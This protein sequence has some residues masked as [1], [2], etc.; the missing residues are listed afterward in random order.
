MKKG[1][2]RKKYHFLLCF[3]RIGFRLLF[4]LRILVLTNKNKKI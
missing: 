3:Y 4:Y 1:I 2:N